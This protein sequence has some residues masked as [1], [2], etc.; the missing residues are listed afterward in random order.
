MMELGF[1][2]DQLKETTFAMAKVA[3]FILGLQRTPLIPSLW[4][5]LRISVFMW[6][7]MYMYMWQSHV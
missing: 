4:S 2:V 5:Q 1:S 7:S 6:Q 3:S